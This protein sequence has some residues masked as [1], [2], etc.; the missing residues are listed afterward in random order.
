MWKVKQAAEAGA[1][2]VDDL[3]GRRKREGTGKLPGKP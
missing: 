3:P 1:G 2:S